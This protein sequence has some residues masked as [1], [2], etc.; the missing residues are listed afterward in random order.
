MRQLPV[1]LIQLHPA[2]ADE[3]KDSTFFEVLVSSVRQLGVIEPILVRPAEGGQYEVIA[4]ERRL[5]AALAAGLETI[6]AVVREMDDATAVTL[7][8]AR[9]DAP[10]ATAA[11]APEED[12]GPADPLRAVPLRAVPRRVE[13][14]PPVRPVK[15]GPSTNLP[16]DKR[17]SILSRLRLTP[18]LF[19]RLARGRGPGGPRQA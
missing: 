7:I 16:A 5:R 10:R 2:R 9:G 6:A 14:S 19:V 17:G 13:S 8:A 15:R 3:L 4:G 1:R 11:P 12:P 18:L